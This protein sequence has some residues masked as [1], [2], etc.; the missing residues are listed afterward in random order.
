MAEWIVRAWRKISN[1]EVA[2]SNFIR[3]KVLLIRGLFPFFFFKFLG[4]FFVVFLLVFA[5]RRFPCVITIT[6]EYVHV[7]F[8]C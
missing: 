7:H 2:G 1:I 5:R 8:P 3:S 6:I 4:S